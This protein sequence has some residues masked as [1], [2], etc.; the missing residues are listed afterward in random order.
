MHWM[1][2]KKHTATSRS[3]HYKYTSREL[4]G[5]VKPSPQPARNSSV[6]AS[7]NTLGLFSWESNVSLVVISFQAR[8]HETVTC[9]HQHTCNMQQVRLL[10]AVRWAP[11]P[12][13]TPS[14][15]LG[16]SPYHHTPSSRASSICSHGCSTLLNEPI[17]Q[18]GISLLLPP[19]ETEVPCW[20]EHVAL[21]RSWITAS[22]VCAAGTR[23][24][25]LL[26]R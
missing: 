7:V 2:Q 12:E 21:V 15:G 8:R 24:S 3:V 9:H 16:T 25:Y 13:G 20:H 11:A 5:E 1:T 23:G 14:N 19:P 17:H 22:S 10:Q 4:K 26:G 6:N 18:S